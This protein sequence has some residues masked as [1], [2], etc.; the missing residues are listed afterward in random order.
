M[1]H[2]YII[3]ATDEVKGFEEAIERLDRDWGIEELEP[4]EY[5]ISRQAVLDIV[6]NPL[7]IRLDE[8]IKKLPPVTPQSKTGHWILTDDDYVYCSECEDSYYARPL[9]ASWYYCPHCG[10]K[11]ESEV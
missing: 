4:C 1:I 6:N 11:M 5:S 9:D 7:N 3:E 2:R 10:A 8:I